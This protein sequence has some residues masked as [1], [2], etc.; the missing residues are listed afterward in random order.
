MARLRGSF[1]VRAA[2][3]Q[4]S[5][6]EGPGG[7][8]V[9]SRTSSG[10]AIIGA[11]L[12]F[13]ADGDTLV[14]LRGN[15]VLRNASGAGATDSFVGAFAIGITTASAFAIGVTAVPTPLT[16]QDWDGWI[17]W[18]QYSVF[19]ADLSAPAAIQRETIDTRAMRKLRQDDVIYGAVEDVE[20]GAMT[21][22]VTFDSRILRKLP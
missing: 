12:T 9:T 20:T 19:G 3:R 15:L 22:Q 21:M 13:L 8:G 16:E 14:R 11:G 6:E 10:V 4:S 7:G 18:V 5:W 1:P 17:Y 2:R